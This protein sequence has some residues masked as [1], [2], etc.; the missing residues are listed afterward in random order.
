MRGRRHRP[1]PCPP[2][3]SGPDRRRLRLRSTGSA[4][5]QPPGGSA[6][7]HRGP[8]ARRRRG[9]LQ[10]DAA[11]APDRRPPGRPGHSAR[12]LGKPRRR[13]QLRPL[14]QVLD[15]DGGA[16]DRGS[17]RGCL[18]LSGRARS[19]GARSDVDQPAGDPAAL[20]RRARCRRRQRQ[21]RARAGADQSRRQGP[22]RTRLRPG[23]TA[24]A[25]PTGGAGAR[26]RARDPGS[27]DDSRRALLRGADWRRR[28]EAVDPHR[29][30]RHAQRR[31]RPRRLPD[32]G[33]GRR[34]HADDERAAQPAAAAHPAR[35][36]GDPAGL[37]ADLARRLPPAGGDRGAGTDP[38]A[39]AATSPTNRAGRRLLQRRRRLLV[40]GAG[41]PRPDRPDLRSRPRPAPR[42]PPARAER[43]NRGAAARGRRTDRPR[44]PHRRDQPA[45]AG[46]P[47]GSVGGVLR[48]P[49]GRDRALLRAALRPGPDRRRYRLRDAAAARRRL[50]DRLALEHRGA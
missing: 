25:A 8:R 2:F 45:R 15:D 1:L 3:R 43:R 17:P 39:T 26:G 41:E 29:H 47:V 23:S 36:P 37:V 7:E 28:R 31:R 24:T 16:G 35:V 18:H 5:R 19:R 48:L 13:L 30:R 27:E 44:V 20:G 33:H 12:L 42:Q 11:R 46:R 9:A 10:S 38:R 40:D 50:D 14:S 4:R 22:C 32:A 49:A 21:R 34:R 6:L